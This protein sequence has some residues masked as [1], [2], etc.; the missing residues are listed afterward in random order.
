MA[1][2]WRGWSLQQCW[3]LS[4]STSLYLNPDQRSQISLGWSSSCGF[5]HNVLNL[6][7]WLLPHT[8]H[9]FWKRSTNS[10]QNVFNI[11]KSPPPSQKFSPTDYCP[12]LP[13]TSVF[14]TAVQWLQCFT[15]NFASH[16]RLFSKKIQQKN[17]YVTRPAISP[18]RTPQS[19]LRKTQQRDKFGM[20]RREQS[21]FWRSHLYTSNVCWL[22]SLLKRVKLKC[23][24]KMIDLKSIKTQTILLVEQNHLNLGGNACLICS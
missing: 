21:Q 19:F 15:S 11:Q 4:A 7:Q 22:F 24:S 20:I 16:Q 5:I 3:P 23:F 2:R 14:Q 1:E 13:P 8:R 6:A 9:L 18:G 12:L 17:W 10:F